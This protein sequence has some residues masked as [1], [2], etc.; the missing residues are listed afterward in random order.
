MNVA[1]DH[2]LY[3]APDLETGIDEIERRLGVRPVPGGRHPAYGTHNALL[4]L[5]SACY[6][7]VIAPDPGLPTPDGGIG[8][9]L[10]RLTGPRLVSWALRHTEIQATAERAGL[11]AVETGERE[12]DDGTVLRWRLTDPYA[13]RMDGVVPFLIDW[14]E[15]PHPASSA[16]YGGRLEELRIEHS[17]PDE[18]RRALAT[19]GCGGMVVRQGESP[20][21]VA[22]IHTTDGTV[23]LS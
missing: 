10:G 20:R 2:L 22:V 6:L 7:E 12:R 21:L 19:L 14:G 13:E 11:G 8:F 3:G 4:S 5:G 17:A 9:G 1:V 18:V 23:E 16:P 15:T